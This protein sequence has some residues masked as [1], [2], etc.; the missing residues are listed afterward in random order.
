MEKCVDYLVE[1]QK[2][3]TFH[4]R[5]PKRREVPLELVHKDMCYVNALSH[6]GGQYFV[7]FVNNYNQKLCAFVLKSKDEVLS[8][9]KEWKDGR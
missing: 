9:F 7:T 8:F 4:S 6:G 2:K 5:P 3:A 1:K